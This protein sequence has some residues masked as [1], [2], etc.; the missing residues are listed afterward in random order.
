M[1]TRDRSFYSGG[2]AT[3]MMMSLCQQH[4]WIV[5]IAFF[6]FFVFVVDLVSHLR[7]VF[8]GKEKP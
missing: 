8:A 4:W 2:I 5:A 6:W 1:N 3:A 7:V